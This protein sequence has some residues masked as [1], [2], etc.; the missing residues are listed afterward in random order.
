MVL[1]HMEKDDKYAA[2]IK[3]I[4]EIYH[5]HKGRYGYRRIRLELKRKGYNLN[6]KTVLRLMGVCGLKSK[7]RPKSSAHTKV[8][9][10]VS[11]PI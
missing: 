2:V 6:G 4:S 7:V 11:H 1:P 5:L 9:S 3:L 8:M 10:G